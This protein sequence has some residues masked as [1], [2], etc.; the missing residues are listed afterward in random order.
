MRASVDA[1]VVISFL[2]NPA[3][4]TPPCKVL[5]A[6]IKNEYHLCLSEGLL[7]EVNEAVRQ[8]TYLAEH[9]EPALLDQ[10]INTLRLSA[11]VFDDIRETP[12]RRVRDPKDD[13]LVAH[14]IA[15]RVNYLVTGDKDLLVLGQVDDLT[16]VTPAEFLALLDAEI[17]L[18]TGI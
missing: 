17:D 14:A 6:G 1:N 3:S 16:I 12:L 5:L 11:D 15:A 7:H 18:G 10:V 4:P 2:L 13:Y 8:K 9:I